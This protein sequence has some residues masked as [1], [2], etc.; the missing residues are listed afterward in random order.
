MGWEYKDSLSSIIERR[1]NEIGMSLEELADKAQVPLYWLQNISTFV[2]GE[3]GDYEIGYDWVTKIAE[4]LNIPG[5]ILR[6]AL[7]KQ[8]IPLPNDMPQITAR[9]AFTTSNTNSPSTIA[10]HFDGDEYTEEELEEIRQFAE[11][12]KAKRK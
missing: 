11:F 9:E 7:A 1:L 5:G 10:A 12:V 3:F 2:P 6:T 4:V 8:E